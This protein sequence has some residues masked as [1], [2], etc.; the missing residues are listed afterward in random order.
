MSTAFEF[1]VF[2]RIR[3]SGEVKAYRS[4]IE[5]ESHLEEIDVQNDEYEAWDAGGVP[6]ALSVQQEKIWLRLAVAAAPQPEQLTMAI[7]KY[8]RRA[9]LD[10]DTTALP[11][12]NLA[13]W[14]ERSREMAEA[15]RRAQPWWR[16]LMQRF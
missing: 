3:D 2:L 12:R 10:I 14:L 16:R 1:P 11:L 15:K 7:A 9:G 4:I 13:T 5:M 6:L 8:A